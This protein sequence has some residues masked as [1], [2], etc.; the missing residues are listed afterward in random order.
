LGLAGCPGGI[1]ACDK[2]PDLTGTWRVTVDP[3]PSEARDLGSDDTVPRS[4]TIDAALT[5]VPPS[6]VLSVGR[7]V[8]GALHASD[9]GYFSDVTIPALDHNNGSK[10]GA[11]LGCTMQINIPIASSVSDDNQDQGPLRI[12]LG[13]AITA[14]G[15]LTGATESSSLVMTSD[16]Q[17]VVRR[18]V[19]KAVRP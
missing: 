17:S 8:R 10:T 13:G 7:Y 12:S 11:V 6:G 5:Q 4:F 2:E 18:F 16:P 14:P 9:P 19:W 15:L 3:V 1:G